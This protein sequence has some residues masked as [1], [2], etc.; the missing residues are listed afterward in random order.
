M[1]C[2]LSKP[3][4]L[5]TGIVWPCPLAYLTTHTDDGSSSAWSAWQLGYLLSVFAGV[6][7]C[8]LLLSYTPS[9]YICMHTGL[10]TR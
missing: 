4:G 6:H 3:S 10:V 7:C 1:Q 5:Y 9:T 8:P 2:G